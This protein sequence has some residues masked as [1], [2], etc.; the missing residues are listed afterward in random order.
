MS[1]PAYDLKH[2]EVSL[3][4]GPELSLDAMP[5][6]R[7][8]NFL[9]C[10]VDCIVARIP[11]NEAWA[12]GTFEVFA[13]DPRGEAIVGAGVRGDVLKDASVAAASVVFQPQRTTSRVEFGPIQRL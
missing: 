4:S 8:D 1:R 7:S 2:Q 3:W 11:K 6:R 10:G 13:F 5:R 12:V 9:R